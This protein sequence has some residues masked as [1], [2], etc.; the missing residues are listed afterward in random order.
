MRIDRNFSDTGYILRVWDVEILV[1]V[2]LGSIIISFVVGYLLKK[3]E[4]FYRIK[5]RNEIK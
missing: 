5:N 1:V 3:Y 4:I 2:I